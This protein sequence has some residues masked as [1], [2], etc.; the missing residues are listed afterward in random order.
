MTIDGRLGCIMTEPV[1]VIPG[2]STIAHRLRRQHH[3]SFSI[4]WVTTGKIGMGPGV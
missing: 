4:A 3:E 2:V 1:R